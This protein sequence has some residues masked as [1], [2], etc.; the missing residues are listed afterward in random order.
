M[1]G[2]QNQ[3][4]KQQLTGRTSS[5]NTPDTTSTEHSRS[6]SG[7]SD[8][9]TKGHHGFE[10]AN[11]ASL[12]MLEMLLCMQHI[13]GRPDGRYTTTWFPNNKLPAHAKTR[14]A[15]NAGANQTSKQY[16]KPPLCPSC[17]AERRKAH[18]SALSCS[19]Q[20][21]FVQ[22]PHGWTTVHLQQPCTKFTE[23]LRSMN[24]LGT[25]CPKDA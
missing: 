17:E 4:K 1:V 23:R 25:L 6:H 11:A 21:S 19:S 3:Q 18:L 15:Q 5:N 8:R 22:H 13:L 10:L 7:R 24:V 12:R 20:R 9:C 14:W 16:Q 2:K